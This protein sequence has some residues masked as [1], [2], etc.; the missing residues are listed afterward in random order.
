MTD[1]RSDATVQLARNLVELLA[2]YEDE[3]IT[4][5]PTSPGVAHLRRAIGMVIAEACYWITDSSGGR[6]YRAPTKGGGTPPI[7]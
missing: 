3:L 1:S 7:D 6:A 2:P 5:E 4:A